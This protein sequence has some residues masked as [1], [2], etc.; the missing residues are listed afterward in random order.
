MDCKRREQN[1]SWIERSSLLKGKL[2]VGLGSGAG[3]ETGGEQLLLSV[4][5]I[6]FPCRKALM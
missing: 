3:K 1:S 2:H 6:I 4:L 5:E